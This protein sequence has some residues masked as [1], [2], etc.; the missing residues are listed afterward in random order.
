MRIA[1]PKGYLRPP[2]KRRDC[3]RC[4]AVRGRQTARVLVLDA[5]DE[6]PTHCATLTTSDPATS[7]AAIRRG[8]ENVVR[9]LRRRYG[10]LEYFAAVEFTT[11]RSERSGGLRRLHLHLLLKVADPE[12]FDVVD[13]EQLVRDSW[14]VTTGAFVVEVAALVSPGAALGYLALHHRKP[15]QAPPVEWRGMTE[16]PSRGY[17]GRPIAELREQA[18]REL[19]VEA[20]AHRHG[21]PVELAELELAARP[22]GR[23]VGVRKRPGSE[24]LEPLGELR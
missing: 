15:S 21:W 18:R 19:A 22:A 8:T 2:C 5:R 4:W 17:F 6:A 1:T 20:I 10:R 16:R 11:G 23:V 14:R 9:R 7:P 24:L 13:A 3:P 12:R